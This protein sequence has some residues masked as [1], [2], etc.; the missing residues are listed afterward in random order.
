STTWVKVKRV[1]VATF[2][3]IGFMSNMP[4]AA[5]SL[6]LAEEREGELVYAGRVGSGIGDSKARELYADLSADERPTASIA[7]PKTPGAHWTQPRWNV[8]VGYR[9]RSSGGAPRAPV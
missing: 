2:V 6:L 4:K 9:S 3:V 5:S 1:D 7:V 8:E